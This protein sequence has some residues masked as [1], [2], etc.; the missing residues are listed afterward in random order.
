MSLEPD[1]I[2]PETIDTLL[3]ALRRK[4]G[5]WVDWGQ[6]CQLLQKSGL[7]PQGIFEETGFEAIQQNQII[8]AAQVYESIKSE[9][10]PPEVLDH[11]QQRGSDLLYEF[12]VLTQ[13]DR[14]RAATIAWQ[15]NLDVDGAHEI[16]KALK[17]YSRL[18]HP[19]VGFSEEMGDAIAH[20]YWQLARQQRD[21]AQRTRL[22]A[23][24]L[25]YVVSDTGRR[26][27]EK[28]LTDLSVVKGQSQPRLPLYRLDSEEELP[29]IIPLIPKFPV[30]LATLTSIPSIRAIAPFNAIQ[31]EEKMTWV[32]LPGWQV[33][34]KAVDPIGFIC[35]GD[36]LPADL[37]N[38]E[39][40]FDQSLETNTVLIVI[41]RQQT[42]WQSDRYFLVHQNDQLTLQWFPEVPEIPLLGQ[43]VLVLRPKKV[44]DETVILEP[45]LLE[46]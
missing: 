5:S 4:E 14:Q 19:P 22:I 1:S 37:P 28:L 25:S 32:A 38:Q 31:S 30:P 12:R 7:S 3:K 20:Y 17:A 35:S 10:T 34:L 2:A 13:G 39:N 24:G 29:R 42:T 40:H 6:A 15:K 46:E 18:S 11:F 33:I 36:D 8:I 45:W 9:V 27:L 44:L 16:A 43:L 26:E 23:Q 41:D 21:L